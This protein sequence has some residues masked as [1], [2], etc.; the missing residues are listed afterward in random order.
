MFWP[1]PTSCSSDEGAGPLSS[2]YHGD[3]DEEEDLTEAKLKLQK[4]TQLLLKLSWDQSQAWG[5]LVTP[6][7]L[8]LDFRKVRTQDTKYLDFFLRLFFCFLIRVNL[9][10]RF[11]INLSLQFPDDC[12]VPLWRASLDLDVPPPVVLQ[13]ILSERAQWDPRRH[14]ASV[15][16]SLSP[17]SDLYQYKIQSQGHDLGSVPPLQHLLLRYRAFFVKFIGGWFKVT[18]ELMLMSKP[19]RVKEL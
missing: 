11:Y 15:V 12:P 8:Q 17:D 6:D 2:G 13:R 16:R 1:G 19:G 3:G 9:K 7:R 4:N 18:D 10:T 5:S 14:R